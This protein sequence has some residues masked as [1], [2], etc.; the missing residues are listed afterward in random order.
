MCEVIISIFYALAV[1]LQEYRR[2]SRDRHARSWLVYS[3]L[4]MLAWCTCINH[5][6][7]NI[8]INLQNRTHVCLHG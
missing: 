6:G 4:V 5:N 1:D 2:E 3:G 8:V 7:S